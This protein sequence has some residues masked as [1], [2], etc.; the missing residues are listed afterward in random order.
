M[1]TRSGDL[2]PAI[3]LHLQRVGGLSAA[4]VDAALNGEAGLAGLCGTG[5]VRELLAREAAGDERATLALELY[6]YRIRKYVGAY[7]AVLGAVDA[8]V[9]TGGVGENAPRVRALACAGLERLGIALDERANAAAA[10]E[11]SEIGRAGMPVRVL[12]VRTDEELQIAREALA[13]VRTGG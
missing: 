4:E 6:A 13:A 1:G 10:G 11:R 12:V 5:D 3:P 9:F 2:D 8:L 7:S